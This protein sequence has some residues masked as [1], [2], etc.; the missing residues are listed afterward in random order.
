MIK[1]VIPACQMTFWKQLKQPVLNTVLHQRAEK[2]IKTTVII[3]IMVT[4][5]LMCQIV[6]AKNTVSARMRQNTIVLNQ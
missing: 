3:S 1:Y 5:I 6:S 4:L 2:Y